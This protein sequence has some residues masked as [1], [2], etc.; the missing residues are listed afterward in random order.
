MMTKPELSRCATSRSATTLR[1]HFPTPVNATTDERNDDMKPTKFT[2][3][4]ELK[5]LFDHA[6]RAIGFTGAHRLAKNQSA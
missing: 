3:E 6:V 1:R 4:A 5:A 2:D